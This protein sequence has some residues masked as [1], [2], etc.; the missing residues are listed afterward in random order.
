MHCDLSN[1]PPG[2][3][4][5]EDCVCAAQIADDMAAENQCINNFILEPGGGGLNSCINNACDCE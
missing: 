3:Q 2:W 1:P 4:T 5:F